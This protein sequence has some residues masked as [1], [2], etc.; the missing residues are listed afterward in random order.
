MPNSQQPVEVFSVP[1]LQG[2]YRWV[3]QIGST[4]HA[5]PQGLTWNTPE[6]AVRAGVEALPHKVAT[7]N[8]TNCIEQ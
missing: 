5:A 4:A 3:H 1:A 2:G 6:E 7:G 8:S